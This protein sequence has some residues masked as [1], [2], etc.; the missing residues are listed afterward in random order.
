MD[1]LNNWT[2][3]NDIQMDGWSGSKV[4][5]GKKLILTATNGW[6]SFGWDLPDIVGKDIIFEF[7]YY[8]ENIA[9][10][11]PTGIFIINLDSITYGTPLFTLE[12]T[13]GNWYHV[14]FNISSAKQFIGVNIRGTDNTG[15]SVIMHV[16]NVR[17][18]DNI[19]KSPSVQKNG[20]IKTNTFYETQ[21]ALAS[22]EKESALA[23]H[24]YEY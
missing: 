3:L 8:L 5:D 21:R 18:Y 15:N 10:L 14:R 12:R 20:Q 22:F 7:D 11:S 23:N 1:Y 17:V 4:F 6:R 2:N 9:N 16:S 24:F 13:T 19:I